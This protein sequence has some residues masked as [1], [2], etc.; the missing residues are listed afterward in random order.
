ML[1]QHAGTDEIVQLDAFCDAGC[2]VD[3]CV[4][5]GLYY[6]GFAEPYQ[7]NQYACGTYYYEEISVDQTSGECQ[8]SAENAGPTAFS[9][10]IPWGDDRLICDYVGGPDAFDAGSDGGSSVPR[11]A[12]DDGCS[13]ASPAAPTV[14]GVNFAM[15]AAGLWIV[16]RA[17]RRNR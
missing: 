3:E 4:G 10:Q 12:E 6:Y 14:L 15:L 13:V 17:R 7:C 11:D 2:Y 9:G 1:R 16:W 5:E 8:R